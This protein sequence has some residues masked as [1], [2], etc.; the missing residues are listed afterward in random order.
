[1]LLLS[2]TVHLIFLHILNSFV[3]DAADCEFM[4][5]MTSN[6]ISCQCGTSFCHLC[7]QLPIGTSGFTLT[8][9]EL[10]I[11]GR[12]TITKSDTDNLC[13]EATAKVDDQVAIYIKDVGSS[14]GFPAYFDQK[15][16]DCN[17][18]CACMTDYP[19]LM[20]FDST[21]GK[22]SSLQWWTRG[23]TGEKCMDIDVA[24]DGEK[25]LVMWF[26]NE[27]DGAGNQAL[28]LTTSTVFKAKNTC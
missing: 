15:G 21:W 8:S 11:A 12:A 16:C 13:F 26:F 25:L 6:P 14:V 20:D 28:K 7:R 17:G 9:V 22:K 19:Y 23:T 1:M 4:N 18:G 24:K 27:D 10:Q 2:A 5:G 3:V